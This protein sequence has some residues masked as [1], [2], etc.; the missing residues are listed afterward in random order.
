MQIY[1]FRLNYKNTKF[2]TCNNWARLVIGLLP[3]HVT[4]CSFSFS[5]DKKTNKYLLVI[6]KKLSFD[7]LIQWVLIENDQ[8]AFLQKLLKMNIRAIWYLDYIKYDP[9]EEVT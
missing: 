9:Y 6:F 3:L 1:M 7:D 5:H 2:D 8:I 4:F